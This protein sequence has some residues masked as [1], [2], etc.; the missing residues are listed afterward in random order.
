[1]K[2]MK[3]EKILF[4]S[5]LVLFLVFSLSFCSAQ[6]LRIESLEVEPDLICR[7][8]E[9]IIKFTAEVSLEEG[10]DNTLLVAKFYVRDDGIWKYVD[11]DKEILD[12][13]ETK[14]F[15][16]YYHYS[17]Y[18]LEEGYHQIKVV[19]ED[20]DIKE[21]EYSE[22]YVSECEEYKVNVGYINLFPDNPREGE[23]IQ[24]SVPISL[25][26]GETPKNVDVKVYLDGSYYLFSNLRFLTLTSKTFK[27]TLPGLESGEHSVKVEARVGSS[28]DS[29]ERDFFVQPVRILDDHCLFINDIEVE[30]Y[31]I[32]GE[33]VR[34]RVY[35]SNCGS[36]FENDI[37]V[38]LNAF[39]KNY[40]ASP[41]DLA[42][43]LM[44]E[45]SFLVSVPTRVEDIENFKVTVWNYYT[46]DSWSKEFKVEKPLILIQAEREFE[47]R[48]CEL[49]TVSFT[50]VNR[51][52]VE[53]EFPI[54]FEGP[55]SEWLE[56]YPQ[57]LTLEGGEEKTLFFN[58]FVPC[59]VKE[60]YYPLTMKIGDEKFTMV[61]HVKKPL[62]QLTLPRFPLFLSLIT[63]LTLSL[64][65][66][67]IFSIVLAL[68]VWSFLESRK[69]PEG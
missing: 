41:F 65:V 23:I 30:D 20:D 35:V 28:R 40:Y 19:I 46:T 6:E 8:D 42:P 64:V 36:Y 13:G 49:S 45:V 53:G 58:V 1:M 68:R 60:G 7:N 39:S 55:V 44:K 61:F 22:F 57:T 27:F 69:K 63:L 16:V 25:E 66:V 31:I 12:V 2:T 32:P 17:P 50:I 9:V 5:S 54:N 56:E 29:S 10:E 24:A 21:K 4:S 11:K 59:D 14:K 47:V 15:K 3:K 51:G 34:V 52:K 33:R 43:G 26:S 67:F 37:R 48:V 62:L 38:K 18:D